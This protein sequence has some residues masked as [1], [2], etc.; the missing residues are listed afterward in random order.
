MLPGGVDRVLPP[1]SG[2]PTAE[3]G[4]TAAAHAQV[5]GSGKY[6]LTWGC[7]APCVGERVG[8][9]PGGIVADTTT[10]RKEQHHG[11]WS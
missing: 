3:G 2:V 10:S 7:V 4:H 8:V 1:L 5:D 11:S 6:A 9:A